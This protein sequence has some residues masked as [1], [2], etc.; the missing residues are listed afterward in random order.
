MRSFH[1][2]MLNQMSKNRMRTLNIIIILIRILTFHPTLTQSADENVKSHHLFDSYSDFSSHV[3]AKWRRERQ[4]SSSIWFVV[5]LFILRWR[6]LRTRITNV[7]IIDIVLSISGLQ[8]NLPQR[9]PTNLGE[10]H[11]II[12]NC[13]N[14]Q[15]ALEKLTMKSRNVSA[16]TW[17]QCPDLSRKARADIRKG[18]L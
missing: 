12:V 14:C 1:E 16:A 4:T 15:R 3:D 6:K 18:T 5:G 7:I 10:K 13:M 17:P 8:T 9:L 2:N 11:I